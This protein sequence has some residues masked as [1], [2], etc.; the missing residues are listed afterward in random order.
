[1]PAPSLQ[2]GGAPI[3][4]PP[5][6]SVFTSTCGSHPGVKGWCHT[7]LQCQGGSGRFLSVTWSAGTQMVSQH[8]P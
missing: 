5:M 3:A 7:R 6:T 4:N 8:D 2:E 1:M